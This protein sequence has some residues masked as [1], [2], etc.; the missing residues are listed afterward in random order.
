MSTG[1]V[2]LRGSRRSHADSELGSWESLALLSTRTPEFPSFVRLQAVSA[3][4]GACI[5]P[6]RLK[7]PEL[8]KEIEIVLGEDRRRAAR[9]VA[10]VRG[11]SILGVKSAHK[12][13]ESMER[14][15]Y[16]EDSF[17]TRRQARV[18]AEHERASGEM[19]AGDSG[20][21]SGTGKRVWR[22]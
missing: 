15:W 6:W 19:R 11:N 17:Y 16:S 12:Q 22:E 10:E 21:E 20:D 13:S 5:C 4:G 9:F 7:E 8:Q 14:Y 3:F 1:W 2:A 18:H